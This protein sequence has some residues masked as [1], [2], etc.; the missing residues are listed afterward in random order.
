MKKILAKTKKLSM[1][2]IIKGLLFMNISFILTYVTIFGFLMNIGV[3][4]EI[5]SSEISKIREKMTVL[6]EQYFLGTKELTMDYAV[7]LG[8]K[9]HIGV[10]YLSYDIN[11]THSEFAMKTK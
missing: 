2:D 7:S 3:K 8:F 5:L 1:K 11:S 10:K 6:D 9:E 4:G